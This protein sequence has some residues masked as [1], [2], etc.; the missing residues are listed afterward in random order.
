[1]GQKIKTV[2]TR[3]KKNGSINSGGYA[4]CSNCGGDGIV[5]KRKKK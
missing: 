5:K 4:I 1:M 2:K 3:V